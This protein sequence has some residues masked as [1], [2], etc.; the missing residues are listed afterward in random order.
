MSMMNPSNPNSQPLETSWRYLPP[1]NGPGP[2]QMAIDHWL[3]EQHRLGHLP[4][5][6]RFYTWSPAAI[7]LGYHQRRWPVDW[8]QLTWQGQA[9]DLV[10]RPTGGRAVLHQGDL[11]YALVAAG[12][13]GQRQQ[14]YTY[15]CEF[16][17]RGWRSLGWQLDYGQAQRG[18][19][20]QPNC[21][22]TATAADLV[23][24]DGTKLIGSAQVWRQGSVLQHGSIRLQPDS[25]LFAQVFDPRPAVTCQSRFQASIPA[26]MPNQ[27]TVIATL[28]QAAREWFQVE[29]V[30]QPLSESEW[31]QVLSLADQFVVTSGVTGAGVTA[32]AASRSTDW[33]IAGS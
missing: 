5:T 15:L 19:I 20:H 1:L 22:A 8:N 10:R 14:T 26:V 11:T 33:A 2:I 7:S 12:Q 6:L 30:A 25:D 17:R 18:D 4:P 27:S 21:F 29:L 31:Q 23:L 32:G 13:P 16:L 24:S 9:V 28:E 3:L